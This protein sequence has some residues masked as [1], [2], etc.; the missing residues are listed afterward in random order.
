MGMGIGT[1][2]AMGSWWD[3]KQTGKGIET[4]IG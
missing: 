2:I 1:K 3:G 4:V